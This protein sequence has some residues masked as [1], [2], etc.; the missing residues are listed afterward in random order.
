MASIAAVSSTNQGVDTSHPNYSVNV[1]IPTPASG[2]ADDYI[3]VAVG[4]RAPRDTN[5]TG[6][7]GGPVLTFLDTIGLASPTLIGTPSDLATVNHGNGHAIYYGP[8]STFTPGSVTVTA[9]SSTASPGELYVN[10]TTIVID[11]SP[12]DPA[13]INSNGGGLLG[14][15]VIVAYDDPG[16]TGDFNVAILNDSVYYSSAVTLSP[17]GSFSVHTSRVLS[18]VSAVPHRFGIAT[19]TD[20]STNGT[21]VTE[22]VVTRLAFSAP[23]VRRRRGLGMVRG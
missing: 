11:G 9:T 21:F 7:P 12:G 18:G 22:G 20:P 10:A 1:S 4:Y 14:T 6:A 16:Y 15:P 19:A 17:A 23:V 8:R 5:G 2:A 13:D 3:I